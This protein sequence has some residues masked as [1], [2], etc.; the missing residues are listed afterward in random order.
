MEAMQREDCKQVATDC[1][2]ANQS[3]DPEILAEGESRGKP[4]I[5]ELAVLDPGH[6]QSGDCGQGEDSSFEHAQTKWLD[7]GLIELNVPAQNSH[8]RIEH[9]AQNDQESACDCQKDQHA[10]A[11]AN[12]VRSSKEAVPGWWWSG[13]RRREDDVLVGH[14]M[15]LRDSAL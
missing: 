1:E 14:A 2:K 6:D 10:P 3:A 9:N 11:G 5:A 12:A 4:V 7:C 13:C 15:S 8:G